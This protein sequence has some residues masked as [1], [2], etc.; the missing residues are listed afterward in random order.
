MSIVHQFVAQI[1]LA[2]PRAIAVEAGA[3]SLTYG[4]LNTG[5]NRVAAYLKTFGATGGRVIGVCL[6]RSFDQIIACL[7]VLKSGAAYLPLD[8]D[9]PKERLRHVLSDAG[10]SVVITTQSLADGISTDECAALVPD[11]MPASAPDAA[12]DAVAAK[13]EDIAYVIY[14]SGSTGAPKGVEVTHG[15]L[16]N[17]ISWHRQA[18]GLTAADRVSHLAGLSFDAS[19]WE[20]WAALSAGATLALPDETTRMSAPLLRDWLIDNKITVAFV[21]TVLAEPLMKANWPG[22]TALRFLLTGADTLHSF[23]P[24]DLPFAVVNNYGPTEC[25]VVATSGLVPPQSGHETSPP[26]G[27][28]ISNTQIY[29]LDREGRPVAQGDSGEIYIGGTGVARGYRNRPDLTAERFLPDPFSAASGARMYRTGDLG[30]LLADGQI[31]F[32][33]RVD[34]QEKIRGYR[35]EPDEIATALNRHP[36]VAS[37]AIVADGSESDRRLVAYVVQ[38]DDADLTSDD[39]RE[40]LAQSLPDHMI[41]SMFLRVAALPQTSSGKLDKCALPKA[42]AENAM[43]GTDYRAPATPAERRVAGIVAKVLGVE[44]VGIDDNFFLIGGHSLLGT[45]VVLQVRQ[46]FGIDLTLR[47]LFTAPTVASLAASVER[48]VIQ[49]IQSMSEEEAQWQASRLSVAG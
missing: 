30:R 14:T 16:A 27:A 31:V 47:H 35:V 1:A 33:G 15:N 45:Q 26:I 40:F 48:L 32:Q 44:R 22:N 2:A 43:L 21:P 24:R 17:L 18:F 5:A 41:P 39:L 10:A 38:S 13:P 12:N 3:A 36:A 29:L 6:P 19:V 20:V 34:N 49:K 46:A 4:E 9:W 23:P 11:G 25:T 42:V 28:P 8:P 37:S 7:A